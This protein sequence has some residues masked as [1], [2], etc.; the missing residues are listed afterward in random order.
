MVSIA[1]LFERMLHNIEKII[2]LTIVPFST[3]I[4]WTALHFAVAGRSLPM[5]QF[6]VAQS[7]DLIKSKSD[8][9]E[10][11]AFLAVEGGNTQILKFLLESGTKAFG[12]KPKENLLD[13]VTRYSHVQNNV[14]TAMEIIN[15]CDEHGGIDLLEKVIIDVKSGQTHLYTVHM[16]ICL[17]IIC[18]CTGCLKKKVNL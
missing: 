13:C 15:Y 4:H 6:L 12:E 16:V 8:D 1:V 7:K 17:C 18:C 14:N 3:Y 5:V 10:T 2:L 9:D 11:P